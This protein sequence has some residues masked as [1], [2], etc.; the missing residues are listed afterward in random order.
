MQ[1]DNAVIVGSQNLA[2][3]FAKAGSKKWKEGEKFAQ[4]YLKAVYTSMWK[5]QMTWMQDGMLLSQPHVIQNYMS[6]V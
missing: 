1:Q 4:K 3:D 2:R 5:I 6:A